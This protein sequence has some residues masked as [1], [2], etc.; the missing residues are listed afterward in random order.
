MK[1]WEN[2]VDSK[3]SNNNHF[4]IT[5]AKIKINDSVLDSDGVK[6]ENFHLTF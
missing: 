1:Y 5:A 2:F 6:S 4:R 3:N